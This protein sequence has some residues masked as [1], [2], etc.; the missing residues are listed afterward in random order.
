MTDLLKLRGGRALSEFRLAKLAATLRK[1][2]PAVR[3]VAAEHWHFVECER[4]LGGAER[5]LLEQLLAYGPPSGA[6]DGM[7]IV[8]VPRL[9][10]LS[11]WASKATDIARNCGLAA[12]RRIE[13]GTVYR[14]EAKGALDAAAL[15]PLLHDRMTETVLPGLEEAAR[16]FQHVPPRPLRLISL[17]NLRIE[18]QNL[19][20]ALSE[21][22]IEYLEAAYRALRRDPTDAELTMF[23]QANSEH[24]RHKIFNA[25]W[26]VDGVRQPE[27]LFA[28]IRRTHA[29]NPQGTVVAYS[30]NAAI[31]EG[32]KALRFFPNGNHAYE[33]H[34]GLTHTVMKCETHNHPTAISPFPGAATGAGGEIRDEG[35]TGRGGKP[36]AGLTGFTTSY[37]RIPDMPRPWEKQRP[38]PPR[39]ASAFEIMRDGPLGAAA[40]RALVA[41]LPA[42]AGRGARERRDRGRVVV[43]LALHDGMAEN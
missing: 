40:G 34:D 43:R 6:A 5:G 36:K 18:N 35:A 7:A 26:I 13:R 3:S 42:R 25:D 19:G 39:M 41:D 24:C 12:V 37:L 11:P 28:M 31:M 8:V 32:R 1:A 21:D 17:R 9:G 2:A 30:D 33:K 15:A 20:L 27:S 23:A 14:I 4:G 16:L 22:E 29:A 38:L 10:T